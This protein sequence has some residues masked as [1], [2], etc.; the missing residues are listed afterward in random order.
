MPMIYCPSCGTRFHNNARQVNGRT[1]DHVLCG[2]CNS[3][4]VIDGSPNH[5]RIMRALCGFLN[6]GLTDSDLRMISHS[7][8][9]T[10]LVIGCLPFLPKKQLVNLLKKVTEAV[11]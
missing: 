2:E 6:D 5:W 9:F 3:Q 7:Y 1:K 10:W 11:Q 4:G 8:A